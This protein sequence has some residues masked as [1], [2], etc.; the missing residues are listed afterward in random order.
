MK[1]LFLGDASMAH[2]TLSRGLR[3]LGHESVVISEKQ[4]WRKF[5]QDIILD[6]KPGMW[7]SLK[8]LLQVLL[9]LPKLRGYDIVQLV[10][11][12][13]MAL[14]KGR[15]RWIYDYLRRHN[16]RVIMTALGV[17]YYWVHGCCDLKLFEYSDFN[18]DSSDRRE[19][20]P[21]VRKLY[22]DWTMP[23]NKEFNE[24]MAR[25]CDA[26]VPVLFEY[27]QCYQ[28]YWK[29]KTV[30]IPLPMIMEDN[31]P[32]D[33]RVGDK[34]RFFLGI[35]KSRSEYKGTDIMQKALEDVV[36]KYPEK[37]EFT[38]VE[39]MPYSE[40]VKTLEGYDVLLD[41][42]YGYSPAMNALLSMSKGLVCVGCG[43]PEHYQILGETE[44]R[45]IVNVKPSYESVYKE[46]E[47][48]IL[49]PERIPE[50]KRQ[51]VEYVRRHH[52]YITVAR[53]YEEFY[54]SLF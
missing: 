6:R 20:S 44:L 18:V 40:Y 37:A 54:R 41:Q 53:R 48:L 10:G 13:F 27:W 9:L 3:K 32:N 50:L 14:R 30:F 21:Y 31:T 19:I 33:F 7:G 39:N 46:L 11:P 34:I 38:V 36:A 28:Q 35:Q 1:I 5:P 43:E 4:R 23:E 12:N 15:L 2:Y 17:D 22:E 51:S 49:H 26:I 16:K 29:D 8:Y 47:N 42:L 24:Y 25:T 52:H 45:P